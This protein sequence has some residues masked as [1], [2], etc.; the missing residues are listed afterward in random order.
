MSSTNI[1]PKY[2]A[3]LLSPL[4]TSEYTISNRKTFVKQTRKEKVSLACEIV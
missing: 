1:S 3:K 4:H 2:L